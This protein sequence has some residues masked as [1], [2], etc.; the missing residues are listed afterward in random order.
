MR[1]TDVRYTMNTQIKEGLVVNKK[2]P[3][4]LFGE[5]ELVQFTNTFWAVDDAHFIYPRNKVQIPFTI[6]VLCWTGA[7]IGAFFPEKENKDKG[8]LRYRDID[9]V[10]KRIPSGGWKVIYRIDQRWVKI[11]VTLRILYGTSTSQH[12]KLLYD[13]TQHLIALAL[14]DNAF[15]GIDSFEDLWQLQIPPGEDELILRWKNDSTKALHIL[16][17]ATM[18]HGVTEEPLP[19]RTFD[20]ILKSVL[21]LS[22]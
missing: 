4:H 14:A 7:R 11:T 12:S 9:L 15:W 5:Q 2:K 6:A 22:G 20:R 1:K 10:L 3:K 16:R 19:K 17:N 18:Q 8:G 21:N 13:D